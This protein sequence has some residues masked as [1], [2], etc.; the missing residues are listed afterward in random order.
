MF[1]AYGPGPSLWESPLAPEALRM[2]AE[3]AR[4]GEFLDDPAMLVPFLPFFDA[5]YGRQSI[6]DGDVPAVDVLEVPVP[7]GVGDPV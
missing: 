3:L 6:P 7:V 2:P 5:R 4:V 1:L